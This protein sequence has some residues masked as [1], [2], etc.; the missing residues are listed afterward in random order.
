MNGLH[1]GFT[2]GDT[3]GFGNGSTTTPSADAN[4]ANVESDAIV[5]GAEFPGVYALH[6][7]R[8]KGFNVKILEAAKDFGGVWYWNMYP[9]ARVDSEWPFYQLHIPE[10]WRDFNY[11][12][13]LPAQ[14][15]IRKYF[16]HADKILN[17]RD[18][19]IFQARVNSA[20]WDESTG[21]YH[22]QTQQGHSAI[23]KYLVLCTGLL[24]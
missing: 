9:G 24:H 7:F 21:R 18:D 22:L 10:V 5:V 12:E 16:A 15:E 14:E 2:N 8:K 4:S 1:S 6:Q 11:T 17:L 20:V 19:T 23:C 13:R 3:H